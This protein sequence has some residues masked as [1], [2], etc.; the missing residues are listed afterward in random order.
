MDYS[1]LT[2]DDSP[3]ITATLS[4]LCAEPLNSFFVGVLFG[5]QKIGGMDCIYMQSRT[6]LFMDSRNVFVSLDTD[7]VTIPT[8]QATDYEYCARVTLNDNLF[9]GKHSKLQQ[10]SDS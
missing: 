6:V 9:D 10:I 4:S 2:S 1:G 3:G 7:V 5:I 8:G